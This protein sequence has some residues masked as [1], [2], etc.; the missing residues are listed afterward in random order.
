MS[1]ETR[2]RLVGAT[3]QLI[4]T[5]R[6]FDGDDELASEVATEVEE[7]VERLTPAMAEGPFMQAGLTSAVDSGVFESRD[8][9]RIFPYSPVI[10][11]L[12]PLSPPAQMWR[13]DDGEVH[14]RVTMPVGHI[15]P[16]ESVH[17]GMVALLFDELLG[18][19][20]VVNGLGAPTGTLKVVYRSF[21]PQGEE[22]TM[23]AR[24]DR[25][26]G[27][28]VYITGEI[29]HGDTLCAEAEGIFIKIYEMGLEPPEFGNR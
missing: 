6:V 20:G 24:I 7:L 22:L 8:P 28:K 23:R 19:T 3:R 12:N 26:E 18:C 13:T 21:T 5:V 15:G 17:G 4:H 25:T 9:M 2:R 16:P 29:H 27:R 1:D 11:A 14:G 10:G